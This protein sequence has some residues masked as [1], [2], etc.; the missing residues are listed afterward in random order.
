MPR[1]KIETDTPAEA[2]NEKEVVEEVRP[3]D[4]L[5]TIND[6]ERGITPED[7]DDVKWN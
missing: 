5:L 2:L 6:Q 3:A 4:D 1:K 7:S